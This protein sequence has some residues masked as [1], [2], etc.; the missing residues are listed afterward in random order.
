MTSFFK[1]ISHETLASRIRKYANIATDAR[2]VS[3]RLYQ[4][5]GVRL[6]Q[7][8]SEYLPQNKAAK[9]RRLALVDT[10]YQAVVDEYLKIASYAMEARIRWETHLMLLEARRSIN[11]FHRAQ[12]QRK[13]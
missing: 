2:Q 13:F 5:I 4:L 8:R 11:S 1:K 9:A 7:Y 3:K 12:A 6:H 10:R